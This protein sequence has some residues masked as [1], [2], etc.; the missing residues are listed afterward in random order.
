MIAFLRKWFIGYDDSPDRALKI[1]K[2]IQKFHGYDEAK[3]LAGSRAARKRTA[4]GKAIAKVAA[5]SKAPAK[6]LPM[7]KERA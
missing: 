2:P 1:Q 3:A 4:T 6:V 7:R 5:K